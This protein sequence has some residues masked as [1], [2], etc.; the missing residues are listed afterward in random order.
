[1]IREVV[2]SQEQAEG[3]AWQR[4]DEICGRLSHLDADLVEWTLPLA[5]VAGKRIV[6]ELLIT[7]AHRPLKQLATL[8]RRI[9]DEVQRLTSEPDSRTLDPDS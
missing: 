4:L 5:E 6:A 1:M 2:Q 3:D 9:A 7:D 8:L